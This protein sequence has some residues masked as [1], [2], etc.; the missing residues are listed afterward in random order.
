MRIELKPTRCVKDSV[1]R[2][3]LSPGSASIAVGRKLLVQF[4]QNS[5]ADQLWPLTPRRRSSVSQ[6]GLVLPGAKPV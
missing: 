3:V 1:P 4:W 2:L 5:A 6:A